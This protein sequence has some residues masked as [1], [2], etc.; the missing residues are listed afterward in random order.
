VIIRLIAVIL[1]VS[2][3][4]RLVNKLKES[5]EKLAEDFNLPDKPET[6][7]EHA[8]FKERLKSRF[9]WNNLEKYSVWL[10]VSDWLLG[11]KKEVN[12]QKL[13]NNYLKDSKCRFRFIRSIPMALVYMLLSGVVIYIFGRPNTPFRGNISFIVNNIIL[14]LSGVYMTILIFFVLDAAYL[15]FGLTE[16]MI[17]KPTEW[18]DEAMKTI[19]DDPEVK[20][21]EFA[22]LL[23]VRF[24]TKHTEDIGKMMYWPFIVLF[25]MI[26][27]R[28]PYFDRWNFPVSLVIAY[29]VPSIYLILFAFKLQ[30][31]AKRVRAKA[32]DYLNERLCAA[33]FGKKEN[34]KRAAKLTHIISEIESIHEGAFR[35]FYE[36]PVVHVLLGSVLAL[37]EYIPLL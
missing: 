27:A 3:L 19:K 26:A 29:F 33:R 20:P 11:V 18:P 14:C 24:I 23:D 28:F 10:F 1:G 7:G 9:S 2:L 5:E 36:N 25:V 30:R 4:F 13:W 34:E 6:E 21:E 8:S 15:S 37:L 31:T 22:E 17:E 12:A 32:L 16:P 35:P